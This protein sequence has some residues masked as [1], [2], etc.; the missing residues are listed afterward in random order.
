MAKRIILY[1]ICLS[2]L[3]AGLLG[4]QGN[5]Q[6]GQKK[7]KVYLNMSYS[8]NTWQGA[9]ANGIKALAATPP[10]DKL[11][12]FKTVISGTDVQRQISDLQSMIAAGADAVIL[13]PLSPTALNRVMKHGCKKGVLFFTYDSTVT[14]PCVVNVSNITARYGANTAQWMVNQL[15]GKGEIVINHGVAG[16]TVTKTYDEQ[17]LYIFKK[18]PGIKIVSEFYGNWNDATSQEEVS[19]ILAAHPN[20]DGIWTVDGTYGSL[21]AVMKNRPD[22]LVVIAGQS[23]NEYR[24]LI[25]DPKF[26]AKGLKGISSSAAPAVGPYAFKLMMEVLLGK[27]KLT[28]NNIEYP[29]PWVEAKDVSVCSGD[30]FTDKCNVF[31]RDKVP[32]LFMDT[33]LDGK[34]I[35]ELS[36]AGVQSGKPA[37]GAT[38][39]PLPAPKYADG[40]PG[41]NCRD[42]A[43]PKDWKEP[44]LVKP[45]PVPK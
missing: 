36:L 45:I 43:R 7:Y 15:G 24:L 2:L 42:C 18:Y 41:I 34:F 3:V 4:I 30:K 5:A 44:N 13:Y 17:A 22:R 12:D 20:I 38:I 39:T 40:L 10:Y 33:A 14:E 27:K 19:K 8:G 11:I 25:A 9:A 6:A 23:N 16:T 29:L 31:P 26:Q 32:P 37:P 1:G 28:S 35:P 21:Q